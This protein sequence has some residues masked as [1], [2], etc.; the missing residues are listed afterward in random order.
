VAAGAGYELLA[1]GV[2]AATLLIAM[3]LWAWGA[4]RVLKTETAPALRPL[5]ALH[6][7]PAAVAGLAA[8]ELGLVTLAQ[9]AAGLSAVILAALVLGAGRLTA[10]GFSALWGAFTF[11]LAATAS[12]WIALGGSWTWPGILTLAAATLINPAI[13][14]RVTKLWMGGQLAVKTNAASA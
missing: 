5:L 14:W 7:S 3:G 11:P 8:A 4:D 12:L 9:I 2:L 1:L 6:L 10:G 13:A